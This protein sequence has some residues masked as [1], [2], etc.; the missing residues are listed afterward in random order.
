MNYK[1]KYLFV[2]K[3]YN[4]LGGMKKGPNTIRDNIITTNIMYVQ[5]AIDSANTNITIPIV[6][7]DEWLKL[8]EKKQDTLLKNINDVLTYLIKTT[9]TNKVAIYN[10]LITKNIFSDRDE[11]DINILQIAI[12]SIISNSI[13]SFDMIEL[14]KLLINKINLNQSI[15]PSIIK[16]LYDKLEINPKIKNIIEIILKLDNFLIPHDFLS[17]LTPGDRIEMNI[18]NLKNACINNY[19]NHFFDIIISRLTLTADDNLI[20]LALVDQL[21]LRSSFQDEYYLNKLKT[22]YNDIINFRMQHLFNVINQNNRQIF[23][24]IM[25]SI[26]L[27]E[28]NTILNQI[29]DLL[30]DTYN[31]QY[32][33]YL[34]QLKTKYH[35]RIN[36]NIEHLQNVIRNNNRQIFDLIII[37]IDLTEQNNLQLNEIVNMLSTR[38]TFQDYH[39]LNVLKNKYAD[40]I[41]FNIQHLQNVIQNDNREIFDLIITSINL[42]AENH[43][44]LFEI[45]NTLC[46]KQIN[47]IPIYYYYLF[48]LKNKYNDLIN[49]T[50]EHFKNACI[51]SNLDIIK[52]L[53]N[54][55][56]LERDD[57]ISDILDN[58]SNDIYTYDILNFFI[59]KKIIILDNILANIPGISSHL[60]IDTEKM[61]NIIIFLNLLLMYIFYNFETIENIPENIINILY[62]WLWGNIMKP[63]MYYPL[64]FFVQA[65]CR[66]TTKQC[67]YFPYHIHL[68]IH[69]CDDEHLKQYSFSTFHDKCVLGSERIHKIFYIRY[70][71]FEINYEHAVAHRIPPLVYSVANFP[72][73]IPTSEKFIEKKR[74]QG[75]MPNR[76]FHFDNNFDERHEDGDFHGFSQISSR[77]PERSDHGFRQISSRYPERS[78]HGFS[79]EFGKIADEGHY[80]NNF[81][82]F[83]ERPF[84][85]PER[86]DHNFSQRPL[87][88]IITKDTQDSKISK[89]T[90]LED[91][92]SIEEK[93]SKSSKSSNKIEQFFKYNIGRHKMYMRHV[94]TFLDDFLEFPMNMLLN[95]DSHDIIYGERRKKII[96]ELDRENWNQYFCAEQDPNRGMWYTGQQFI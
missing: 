7:H 8:G 72:E 96:Y 59:K 23:D 73:Q 79:F 86:Y 9:H 3:Q 14:I 90:V 48:T 36:F 31:N 29:V 91:S 56:K 49:F 33:Y 52:F 13:S 44:R 69:D 10:F 85:N 45:V 51:K 5:N 42:T 61:R 68:S 22:Q 62:T 67:K 1:D 35:D 74:N 58:I 26:S 76:D 11:Y 87:E 89:E 21:C 81:D 71:Q 28:N 43:E 83:S 65:D 60:Y 95:I 50:I 57:I 41:N 53:Y 84:G 80:Y 82:D 17:A 2:K 47:E 64:G 24:L 39:Y 30:C 94:L 25:T 77:Y 93:T 70:K 12:N 6:L 55:I 27:P 4:L 16:S 38:C 40:S 78:N 37:S 34:N 88:P 20:L 18:H 75:P 32:Y 19:V 15:N 66:C 46:T 54:N 92:E 63:H